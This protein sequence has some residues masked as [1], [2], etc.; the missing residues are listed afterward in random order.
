M[1]LPPLPEPAHGFYGAPMYTAD[2][3]YAY[4]RAVIAAH[5]PAQAAQG[6]A[7]DA[8]RYRWLRRAQNLHVTN[9]VGMR[10]CASDLDATLDAYMQAAPE[11]EK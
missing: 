11:G 3:M 8:K 9:N 6:D 10:V 1:S 7:V 2:Q 5:P 4:A